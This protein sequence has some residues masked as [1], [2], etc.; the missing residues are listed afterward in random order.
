MNY[1]VFDIEATCDEKREIIMETIEIGALKLNESGEIIGSF[2][3]LVCPAVSEVNA[4]CTKLTGIKPEDVQNALFFGEAMLRF[5]SFLG[6]D[7]LMYSW[8]D[9]DK[10]QLRKDC[11]RHHTESSF[12]EN[13]RNLKKMYE[14]VTGNKARGLQKALNYFKIEFVGDRHR[15]GPDAL[16]T[17][18]V[19]QQLLMKHVYCGDCVE[20]I[21]LFNSIVAS[22]PIPERCNHCYAFDPE[23]SYAV[24]TRKMFRKKGGASLG[25]GSKL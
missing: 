20:G 19:F 4:F 6:E 5:K 11:D 3:T 24:N 15:A 25:L 10:N 22:S 14:E 2:E 9:Y 1:I 23:D 7:Y 13:H 16:A 12:L 18:K 17:A 21:P 8:G